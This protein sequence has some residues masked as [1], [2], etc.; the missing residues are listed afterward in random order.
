MSITDGARLMRTSF[1]IVRRNRTLLW[2]P[3]IST[4]SLALTA[5]FWIFEGMWCSANRATWSL[6]P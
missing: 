4:V 6:S 3:V 2:F 1:D 5:G